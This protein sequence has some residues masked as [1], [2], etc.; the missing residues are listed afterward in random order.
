MENEVLETVENTVTKTYDK[1]G[2]FA[3]GSVVVTIV[4]VGAFIVKKICDKKKAEKNT[5]SEPENLNEEVAKA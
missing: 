4:A 3:I 5:E 1:R 2:L